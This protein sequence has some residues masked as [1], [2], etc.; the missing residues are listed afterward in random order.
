MTVD[1]LQEC[2][3]AAEASIQYLGPWGLTRVGGETITKYVCS[4][5]PSHAS[6]RWRVGEWTMRGKGRSLREALEDALTQLAAFALKQDGGAK[7]PADQ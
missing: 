5:G 1:D 7:D 2:L 4:I 6:E 3:E